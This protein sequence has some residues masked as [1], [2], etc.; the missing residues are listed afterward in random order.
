MREVIAL[1]RTAEEWVEMLDTDEAA[2]A[3]KALRY[4]DGYQIREVERVLDNVNR[5]RKDWQKRG[6]IP[7]YRNIT[8]MVVEKSGLL[9]THHAPKFEVFNSDGTTLNAQATDELYT[10][11]AKTEWEETFINLDHV[12]RLLKTA[13][14]LT[15]YDPENRELTFDIL[16]R[17]NTAL[18][19][20]GKRIEGFITCVGHK[21]W[22][23]FTQKRILDLADTER[24]GLHVYNEVIN[25]YGC[26]PLTVFYDTHTPRHGLWFDG[27]QDL[28]GINEMYNLHLTDSEFAMKWQKYGTVVT[29]CR[30][31]NGTQEVD[32]VN[33]DNGIAMRPSVAQ[34]SGP[35]QVIMLDTANGSVTPYFEYKTT[36][37]DITPL[38]TTMNQWIREF[39][40]DWSVNIKVAGQGS[41]QSGFQLVVEEM[42]NL[43]LRKQRQKMFT[44]GFK[45][46]F[47]TVSKLSNEIGIASFAEGQEL[48]V[49]FTQPVLPVNKKEEEELW[50]IRISSGRATVVDYFMETQGL[51]K[52]EAINKV[53]EIRELSQPIVVDNQ[54]IDVEEV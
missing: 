40:A 11:F 7:R 8:K 3:T 14:I 33:G 6:I 46:M 22:R 19:T 15:Q 45:R 18:V 47:H 20:D 23:I 24:E 12:V 44:A 16:H 17:G 51:S 39:A 1:D 27:G 28:I 37:I 38:E 35:D 13:F 32:L 53:A 54:T 5:G 31:Q 26:I 42:D 9:F 34:V 25:H 48:F 49:Q 4:L 30:L 50:S 21:R 2:M 10:L 52:D 36:D 29:N 43:E 41:A